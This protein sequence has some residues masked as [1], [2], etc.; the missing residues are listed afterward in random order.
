MLF[1][2]LKQAVRTHILF[3]L[4][5]L[6]ASSG[7]VSAQ[8]SDDPIRFLVWIKNDIQAA[9]R[10]LVRT[11]PARL[12][13]S[14]AAIWALSRYDESILENA[15]GW[16]NRELMRVMEEMGDANAVRPLAFVLFAGSLFG[17]NHRFQDAAFT[18]LESLVLAN[19]LTNTLKLGFGRQRPWQGDDSSVFKPFSGNTSFPSG[20]A[21]TAF[22]AVTPWVLYYPGVFTGVLAVA[23]AGT[24]LSRVPLKFHWPSDVLAGAILGTSV[25]AWLVRRHANPKTSTSLASRFRPS[26]G[27][28][29]FALTVSF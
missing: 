9:P 20:H 29:H 12:A 3:L 24:A 18:S 16:R 27:P 15:L 13:G 6:I 5:L 28:S 14:G 7:S 2:T 22:A 25:S 10:A 19:V 17:S 8:S 21:T 4:I 23:A 1:K 11:S 26:I